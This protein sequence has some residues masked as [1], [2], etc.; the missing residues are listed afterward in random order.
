[1]EPINPAAAPVL[2]NWRR[3]MTSSSVHTTVYAQSKL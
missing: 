1:V 2:K 3:S